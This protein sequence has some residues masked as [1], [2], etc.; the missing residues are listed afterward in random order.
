M[1]IADILSESTEWT[2]ETEECIFEEVYV[3]LNDEILSE[4]AI[5]QWKKQGQK[6]VRKYR[7]LAGKK[8]GRL[9]SKPSD[10]ATR[11]DPAKV[12][13]GK[14][15]MRS[16]KNSIIRKS[17]ISKRRSLSKILTRLNQKLSGK[18]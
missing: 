13:H 2:S 5:R 3:D 6:M 7:C 4:A 18:I 17:Q 8:K 10:C 16:K 12:R 1:K 15:V 9:A 14:K 11:K